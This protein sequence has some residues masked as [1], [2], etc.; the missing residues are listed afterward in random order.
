MEEIECRVGYTHGTFFIFKKTGNVG[1]IRSI[2]EKPSI[3]SCSFRPHIASH[4]FIHMFKF[5]IR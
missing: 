3:G 4:S 1:V 5:S 2:I